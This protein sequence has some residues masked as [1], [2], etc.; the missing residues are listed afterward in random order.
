MTIIEYCNYF[1]LCSASAY[2]TYT[3]LIQLGILGVTLLEVLILLYG[4][5]T[6]K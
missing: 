1:V 3:D 5:N 4:G 2:V 6:K